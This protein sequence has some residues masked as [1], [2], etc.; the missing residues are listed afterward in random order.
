M[1]APNFLN[2]LTVLTIGCGAVLLVQPQ[3]A[4]AQMAGMRHASLQTFPATST[5]SS[6]VNPNNYVEIGR[7]HV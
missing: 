4:P 1:K 3:P 7:A 5:R 2:F 6:K